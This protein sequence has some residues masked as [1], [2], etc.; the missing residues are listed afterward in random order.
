[1]KPSYLAMFLFLAIFGCGGSNE[2]IPGDSAGPPTD[3][4][5]EEEIANERTMVQEPTE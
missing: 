2:V 3:Q 5:S 1:M 4:L